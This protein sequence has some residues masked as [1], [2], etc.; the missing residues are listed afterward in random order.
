MR[1]LFIGAVEFSACALRELIEMKAE[2]VGVCT[3]K[4]SRFNSDHVDLAPIANAAGIPVRHTPDLNK[5]EVL[6]WVR[7]LNPEVIFC[8]GWSLLIH[9]PLLCTPRLGVVG[10]HPAAL[11]KNR[12]R[13]PLIWA[14][15]LGL[16]VTA[17]TFFFMNENADAGDILSQVTVDIDPCDDAGTLYSRIIQVGLNQIREF[18]PMLSNGKFKRRSQDH[19]IANVW[20]KRSQKDG[21]IDW[22]MSAETIHNL[23]RGLARPYVGAEFDCSGQVV[24]VWKTEIELSVSMNIEPGKV[25]AIE[26]RGILVKVGTGAIWLCDYMPRVDLKIGEYL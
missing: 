6:D 21:L 26:E 7:E 16:P 11:P 24:K 1:I 19:Q 18:V 10:F 2:V 23:V 5:S 9:Q 3:L 17:S 4:I 14:L 12:G 22:R 20:R 13:H 15:V 25:L 8:F